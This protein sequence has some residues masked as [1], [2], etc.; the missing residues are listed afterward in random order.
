[1]TELYYSLPEL[2]RNVKRIDGKNNVINK[3]VA[4]VPKKLD[5]NLPLSV[6]TFNLSSSS[7]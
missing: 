2:H 3:M 7:G 4:K 6:S 5:I 1:M